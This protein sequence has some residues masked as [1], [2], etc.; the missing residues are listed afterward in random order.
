MQNIPPWVRGPIELLQHAEDHFLKESDLDKRLA[1]ISFDNA[2]EVTITTYLQLNPTVRGGKEY[3]REEIQKWLRNYHSKI[4]FLE[5]FSQKQGITLNAKIE[6][7]IWYHTLRN[8][9]Y[10]SGN[11]MVPEVHCIEGLRKAAIEV[12]ELIFNVDAS[13]VLNATCSIELQTELTNTTTTQSLFLQSFIVLDRTLYG[14]ALALGLEVDH[15]KEPENPFALWRTLREQIGEKIANFDSI[16]QKAIKVR[17]ELI[18]SEMT[19]CTEQELKILAEGL[20]QLAN[21][22]RS[23]G[24]SFNILPELKIRYG[25]WVEPQ[26]TNVRIIHKSGS[27]FLEVT[28]HTS[29]LYDEEVKR[30]NLD[31]IVDDPEMDETPLFSPYYS[32][33]YNAERFF[34][35]LDLYSIE[36]TGI[37][38]ILFTKEGSDAAVKY[39]RADKGKIGGRIYRR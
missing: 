12:M 22:L 6:E 3:T 19:N 14:T 25:D 39:C 4:Q 33:Q 18:Y 11:G 17:N 5:H 38:D 31:F 1:L 35:D 10:H 8:E 34:N 20:E 26:I 16:V 27:A 21:Y 29:G 24:F 13:A 9:L 37:G 36:M 15:L 7:I 28:Q 23:Y 2:L 30:I 32:A